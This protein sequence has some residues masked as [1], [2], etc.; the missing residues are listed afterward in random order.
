MINDPW[1][2]V[3][4]FVMILGHDAVFACTQPLYSP[5]CHCVPFP[6]R[7]PFTQVSGRKTSEQVQVPIEVACVY[8]FIAPLWMTPEFV[9]V[10]KHPEK[11]GG[12]VHQVYNVF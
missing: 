7:R 6:D 3:Q 9:R 4:L 12:L 2:S 11:A 8:A 1:R 10:F 5:A